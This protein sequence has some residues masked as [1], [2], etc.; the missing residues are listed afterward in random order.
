MFKMQ[1]QILELNN[2][3]SFNR[4]Y[5]DFFNKFSENVENIVNIGTLP[6][7]NWVHGPK[8]WFKDFYSEIL[9]TI[10]NK[11]YLDLI[12]ITNENVGV[13]IFTSN[14]IVAQIN[15]FKA[16]S[17]KD[18]IK[19]DANNIL[20]EKNNKIISDFDVIY[21]NFSFDQLLLCL[22]SQGMINPKMACKIKLDSILPT[23]NSYSNMPDSGLTE[24]L[25]YFL[26][27]Y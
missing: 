14:S 2:F 20:L 22:I 16:E 23:E 17:S 19:Y 24:F 8:M 13:V 1:E 26:R 4:L 15:L 18:A 25:K 10:M 7:N 9:P 11:V 21:G 12:K 3:K 5:T 27:K 6:G